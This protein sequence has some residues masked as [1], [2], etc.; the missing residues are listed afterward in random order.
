MKNVYIDEHLSITKSCHCVKCETESLFVRFSHNN[1]SFIVGG[2]YWHPDGNSSHFVKDLDRS[3]ENIGND[4][5]TILTGDL[6]IDIF[7][8]ENEI[9]LEYVSTLRSYCFLPYITL[10]S[11]ITEYSATCI[12]HIFIKYAKNSRSQPTSTLS[13]MFYCDITDH[14]PCF[15]SLKCNL[16]VDNANRPKV[17]LLGDKNCRKFKELMESYDWNTIYLSSPDLYRSFI[18]VANVF[19]K[20]RFQW[21]H[22][23]VQELETSHELRRDW[24]KA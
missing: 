11:R 3:S 18:S 24:K 4:V 15:V 7:K 21:W 17:R 8:I 10:P 16:C 1:V 20:F 9:T 19:T 2:I 14:L 6:N 13:G 12:D 5:T 23:P 22:F